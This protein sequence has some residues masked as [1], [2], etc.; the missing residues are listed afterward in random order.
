MLRDI[1]TVLDGAVF[2][3]LFFQ[4]GIFYETLLFVLSCAL[5]CAFFW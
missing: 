1:P 2:G 3:F 4:M 5:F